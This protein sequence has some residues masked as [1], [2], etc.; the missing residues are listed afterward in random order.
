MPRAHR[1]IF[2][3]PPLSAAET[4]QLKECR[5]QTF[6]RGARSP[7]IYTRFR[8]VGHTPHA[9]TLVAMYETCGL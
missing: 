4:R 7:G 9:G 8:R 2:I 6:P 3:N 1:E 5:R